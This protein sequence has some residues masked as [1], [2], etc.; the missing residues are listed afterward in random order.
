M[1]NQELIAA[2]PSASKKFCGDP[3]SYRKWRLLFETY[4]NAVPGISERRK[5]P[6]LLHWVAGPALMANNSCKMIVDPAKAYRLALRK[7]EDMW[8]KH[9]AASTEQVKELT[10]GK[11]NGANDLKGIRNLVWEIEK[12]LAHKWLTGDLLYMSS[13]LALLEIV[14]NW[15]PH[16]LQQAWNK[17]YKLK[18]ISVIF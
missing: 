2:Q 10:S 11:G 3:Y 18:M 7:L 12:V 9:E 13:P 1:G 8:G 5:F 15:L 4:V 17:V 6:E 14:E 16:A